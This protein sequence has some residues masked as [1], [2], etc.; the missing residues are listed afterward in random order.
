MVLA[1]RSE[2]DR[3]RAVFDQSPVP[4]VVLD[5]RGRYVEVNRPAR[6]VLHSSLS[7]MRGLTIDDLIP[8]HLI[9]TKKTVWARLLDT[10]CV[11]GSF[12]LAGPDGCRLDIVYLA[13]ANALPGLHLGAFVPAG[14]SEDELAVADG[15]AGPVAPLTPREREILQLA[16]DGLSGPAIADQLVVSPATVKVHFSNIYEKLRASGRA[17]AVARGI[18]LWLIV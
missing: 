12:E 3:M 16:A 8:P 4:M 1:A 14:W 13:V 7:E 10:G 11:A 9:P 5:D 6:L 2:A 15:E 18:R 17:A